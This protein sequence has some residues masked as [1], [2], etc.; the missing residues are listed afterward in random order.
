[1][2][3]KTKQFSKLHLFSPFLLTELLM[4]VLAT[5]PSSRIINTSSATHRVAK[6]PDF[7]DLQVER[8]YTS[9]RAYA[10]SK[11]Y[12]IWITRHLATKLKERGYKNITTNVLHPGAVATRFGQDNDKG[13]INNMIFKVALPFMASPEKGAATTVYLATSKEV[14]KVTGKFF[15]NMKEKKPNDKHYSAENEKMLWDYCMKIIS[16]FLEK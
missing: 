1:M 2:R 16:T 5:S 6:K 14:E 8:N 11:L 9:S 13:F 15:G 4:D 10:L 3:I 12:T 7:S